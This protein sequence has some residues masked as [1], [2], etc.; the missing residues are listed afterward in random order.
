MC[1]ILSVDTQDGELEEIEDRIMDVLSHRE[2]SHCVLD[3]LSCFH[4]AD[5]IDCVLLGLKP[6]RNEVTVTHPLTVINTEEGRER[7]REIKKSYIT[8]LYKYK[9]LTRPQSLL[10]P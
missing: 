10:V 6:G 4:V 1:C 2:Q 5:S 7:E 8:I 3:I 9:S